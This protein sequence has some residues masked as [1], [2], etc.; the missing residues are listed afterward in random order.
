[1]ATLVGKGYIFAFGTAV[2]T[3]VSGSPLTLN[4]QSATL[5]LSATVGEVLAQTGEFEGVH[6]H[7][8]ALT[9]EFNAIPAGANVATAKISVNLG[10]VL[11]GYNAANFPIVAMGSFVDAFNT[12]GNSTQPWLYQGD[13][14]LSL[15][16]TEKAMLTFTMKRY[17]NITSA[18]VIT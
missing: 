15:T 12:G 16:N 7:G 5:S 8:E 17:P 14:K 4:V 1:M 11:Q 13:A 10:G 9:C 18:T 6:S 3:P 2:L